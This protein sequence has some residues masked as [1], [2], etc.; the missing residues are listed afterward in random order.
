MNKF[1]I[2]LAIGLCVLIAACG[3]APILPSAPIPTLPPLP[4][5]VPPATITPV[6]TVAPSATATIAVTASPT[7]SAAN[8]ISQTLIART[9]VT[10]TTGLT[11]TRPAA[12]T[13]PTL[14]IAPTSAAAG[15]PPGVYV[16]D[17][18]VD[19]NPPT[20]TADL[21][22]YPI[23]ANNFPTVQ[24]YRWRVFIYKQDN[25]SRSIGDTT[26]AQSAIT[27]GTSEQK[28]GGTW[29]WGPGN[30]CDYFFLRV[31]SLDQDNKVTIFSRPDGKVFEKNLTLCP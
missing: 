27:V 19:P 23:F 7:L 30:Q 18:R 25:P 14:T 26:P 6:A 5:L 15:A 22:F 12:T 1:V 21:T 28:P 16:I 8:A 13:G 11:N 31:G 17:L 4:S 10:T 2:A 24:N 9:T 20:R 3:P 29:K